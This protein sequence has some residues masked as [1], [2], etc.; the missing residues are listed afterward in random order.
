MNIQQNYR[1]TELQ[2]AKKENNW[3]MLIENITQFD[4]VY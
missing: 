3:S 4:V 1:T 2:K